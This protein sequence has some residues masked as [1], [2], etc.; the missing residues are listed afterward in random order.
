MALQQRG[1]LEVD[2]CWRVMSAAMLGDTLEVLL[3]TSAQHGWGACI[4]VSQACEAMSADGFDPRHALNNMH[5][6]I[7]SSILC[8]LSVPALPLLRRADL[9]LS[10]GYTSG[11][12]F[13]GLPQP[14]PLKQVAVI[15]IVL[16]RCSWAL[17][18]VQCPK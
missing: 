7:F 14:Q 15:W 12:P 11:I 18:D 16:L 4:P 5:L 3:L 8:Q 10:A 17:C 2:G 9:C 6:A 13:L 1:A